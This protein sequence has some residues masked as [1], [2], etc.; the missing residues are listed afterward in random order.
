[1]L[2]YSQ[3]KM[4]RDAEA[5]AMHMSPAKAALRY[6]CTELHNNNTTTSVYSTRVVTSLTS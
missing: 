2:N 6:D 5:I 4:H 3:P 1:M